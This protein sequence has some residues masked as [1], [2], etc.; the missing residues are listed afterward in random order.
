MTITHELHDAI[1]VRIQEIKA[2]NPDLVMRPTREEAMARTKA[3]TEAWKNVMALNAVAN[4]FS[5]GLSVSAT[6]RKRA[7]KLMG[8]G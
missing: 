6:D 2:E 1:L 8:E 3:Q 7:M 4:S 5:S